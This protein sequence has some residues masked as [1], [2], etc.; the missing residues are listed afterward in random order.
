MSEIIKMDDYTNCDRCDARCHDFVREKKG[1]LLLQCCFCSETKW[2]FG[3]APVQKETGEL[4]LKYGRHAG[5]TL[6]EIINEPRGADYLRLLAQ[7]SPKLRGPIEDFLRSAVSKAG[8]QPHRPPSR[9]EASIP[10][11]Q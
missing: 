3:K 8:C 10:G 5:K 7:D 9:T 6:A 1:E 4:R 2:V 11:S